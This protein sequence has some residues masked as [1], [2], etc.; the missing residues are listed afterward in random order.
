MVAAGGVAG[1]D[2]D[3]FM[4]G[5]PHKLDLSCRSDPLANR[6]RILHGRTAAAERLGD[7]SAWE[8]IPLSDRKGRLGVTYVRTVLAQAALPNEETTGGEDHMAVDLNVQFPAAPVR[9]QVKCGTRKPG[10]KRLYLG[11]DCVRMARSLV[12]VQGAR[13]PGLRPAGEG[14]ATGVA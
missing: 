7:M 2:R 8:T 5:M 1:A 12:H 4:W 11:P 9:V 10:K 6:S 3:A 14:E 13:L